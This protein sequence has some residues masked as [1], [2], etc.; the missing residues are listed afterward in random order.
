MTAINIVVTDEDIAN[1]NPGDAWSCPITRAAKRVLNSE[2]RTTGTFLTVGSDFSPTG[3][4]EVRL[5]FEG[6]Q[7]V[8]KFDH[9]QRVEP[10]V[11]TIDV[12]EQ[13]VKPF[14]AVKTFDVTVGVLSKYAV[15][16]DVE[17]TQRIVSRTPSGYSFSTPVPD[18][19][20]HGTLIRPIKVG[21]TMSILT[22]EG[23]KRNTDVVINI[24]ETT[25][26]DPL[27]GKT[28]LISRTWQKGDAVPAG[29]AL[30]GSV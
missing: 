6:S 13:F 9:A 29:W 4:Y 26:V 18:A 8:D 16:E 11:L 1:G 24:E 10:F 22:D 7:F 12:P 25:V 5:P 2:V 21:Q 20:F 27:I 15:E 28:V 3:K 19:S 30:V 14:V 17:G 23:Q